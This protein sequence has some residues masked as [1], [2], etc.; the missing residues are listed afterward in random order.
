MRRK[1]FDSFKKK[2]KSYFD[3]FI[4]TEEV[5]PKAAAAPVEEAAPPPPEPEKKKEEEEVEPKKKEEEEEK[6][7]EPKLKYVKYIKSQNL[8]EG[9]SLTLDCAYE[10][11]Y[12]GFLVEIFIHF[13]QVPMML[14]QHGYEII[15]KFP[16]IQIFVVN[17]KAIHLNQ[18]LLKCKYL[19]KKF[20]SLNH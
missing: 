16:T 19:P 17:E 7:A 1:R 15:K 8:M 18:L 3:H 4:Q 5:K 6:P 13:L 14:N 20:S 10:G 11:L 2:L 9:D 12:I